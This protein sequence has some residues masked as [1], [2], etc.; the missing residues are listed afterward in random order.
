MKVSITLSQC[1][2]YAFSSALFVLIYAMLTHL[3]GMSRSPT[4][5]EQLLVLFVLQLGT[6][7]AI[8]FYRSRRKK[9]PAPPSDGDDSDN[10]NVK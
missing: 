10:G 2:A 7:I 9:S 5:I 3:I 1:G 6:N 4:T 8:D